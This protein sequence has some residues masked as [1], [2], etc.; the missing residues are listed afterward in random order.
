MLYLRSR[1]E[2]R[3]VQGCKRNR[4]KGVHLQ[5]SANGN[6]SPIKN[7]F[8][9]P[10]R[11]DNVVVDVEHRGNAH[12]IVPVCIILLEATVSVRRVGK[13]PE[14]DA[15]TCTILVGVLRRIFASLGLSE[16]TA[17][18]CRELTRIQ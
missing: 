18:R 12:L 16:A 2:I 8:L 5:V 7:H 9:I 17:V 15:K 3:T 1:N 13:V 4:E 6:K 11:A 14:G 10:Q